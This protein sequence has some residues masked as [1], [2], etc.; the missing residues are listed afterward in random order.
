MYFGGQCP[1]EGNLDMF[2][3]LICSTVAVLIFLHTAN[4][5]GA[6]N[7]LKKSKL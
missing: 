4:I 3:T 5:Q 6:E 7:L 2:R 1:N